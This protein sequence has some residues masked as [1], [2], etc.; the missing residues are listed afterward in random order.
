MGDIIAA[1]ALLFPVFIVA[2]AVRWVRMIR[3]NSEKQIQ[4]NKE[5]ISL[6][7]ENKERGSQ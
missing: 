6:L 5:I 1:L 4:Q 3:I 2:M 7:K